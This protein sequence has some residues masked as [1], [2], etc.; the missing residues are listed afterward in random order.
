M[1]SFSLSLSLS[2]SRLNIW[3]LTATLSYWHFGRAEGLQKKN[4]AEEE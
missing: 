1:L 2:L 4:G 3:D